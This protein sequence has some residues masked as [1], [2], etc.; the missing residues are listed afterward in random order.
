MTSNK[1][2]RTTVC[3][4]HILNTSSYSGYLIFDIFACFPGLVTLEKKTNGAMKYFKL[5]RLVHFNRFFKQL[6][7]IFD[8]V[9]LRLFGYSRQQISE[10][11][12]FIKLEFFV[13][14]SVHIM[15][16]IWIAIGL[17]DENYW[18]T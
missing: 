5:T 9:L 1:K 12:D 2:L 7:I 11:V 8:K 3:N 4:P 15:A 6:N 16:L 10:V 13:L 17:T 18:V 14:F